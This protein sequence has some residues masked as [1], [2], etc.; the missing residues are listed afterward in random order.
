MA[1]FLIEI[2]RGRVLMK[3]MLAKSILRY[4][5]GTGKYHGQNYDEDNHNKSLFI[6]L[7]KYS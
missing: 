5:V 6:F 7:N 2:T 4:E 1:K 3:R